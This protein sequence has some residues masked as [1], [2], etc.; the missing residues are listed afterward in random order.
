M[1][2]SGELH[3][4]IV[5]AH[6]LDPVRSSYTIGS[7]AF[8]ARVDNEALRSGTS[9]DR[10][11]DA[12]GARGLGGDTQGNHGGVVK[13]VGAGSHFADALAKHLESGRR[14]SEEH[15]SE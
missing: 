6:R 15:T 1:F 9:H 12:R 4:E 8:R 10:R 7:E 3:R 5:A 14:R 11:H 2:L 13:N